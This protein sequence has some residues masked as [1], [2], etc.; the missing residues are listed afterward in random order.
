LLG[1]DDLRQLRQRVSLQH[2]IAPLDAAEVAEYIRHRL[3]VAGDGGQLQWT[4]AALALVHGFAQGIPR[5]INLVCDKALMAGYVAEVRTIDE[6]QVR[7]A[8]GETELRPVPRA[9]VLEAAAP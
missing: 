8:I 9:E 5:L 4:P 1:R 3:H 7:L 6:P 2:H